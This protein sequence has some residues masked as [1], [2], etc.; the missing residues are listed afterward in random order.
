MNLTGKNIIAIGQV[1]ITKGENMTEKTKNYFEELNEINV[2]DKIE[3]KNGLSYLSWAWAWGEL[4]KKY[5]RAEKVVY[6]NENGWLYHTDGKTCWVEVAVIIP[7]NDNP[8]ADIKEVEYLPVM[9]FKNQ[10]VPLER[11]TSTAVNTTIQRAITKA[12]ARHGLGLYIYAGEDLPEGEE[13]AKPKKESKNAF[14]LSKDGDLASGADMT[15]TFAK[16]AQDFFAKIKK[17]IEGCGSLAE[18]QGLEE[19]NKAKIAKLAKNYP[20][21]HEMLLEAIDAAK[22]SVS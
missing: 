9:D 12:I 16:A 5:P 14:G 18:V 22:L 4:K 13:V 7:M 17:D 11:I 15:E 21:L 3:K 19:A 6:K 10:A 8:N 20:N 1:K 2:S